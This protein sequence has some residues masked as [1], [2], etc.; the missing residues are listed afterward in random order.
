MS[1]I[2]DEIL[3]EDIGDG[4][5][6]DDEIEMSPEMSLGD[7]CACHGSENVRNI[8]MHDFRAP[9]PGTGWGCVVCHLPMDGAVS[10]ICDRCR[11]ARSVIVDVCAGYPKGNSRLALDGFFKT[12]F[13]HKMAMH[14]SDFVRKPI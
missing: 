13:A 4:F 3:G 11:D 2:D 5:F 6:G 14:E 12:P 10:V 1:E 9:V 8:V 7:C